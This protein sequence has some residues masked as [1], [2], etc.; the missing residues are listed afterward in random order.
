MLTLG[1]WIGFGLLSN[2]GT[3]VAQGRRALGFLPL[4]LALL[5]EGR[6]SHGNSL[7]LHRRVLLHFLQLIAV[8][9]LLLGC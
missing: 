8:L 7:T 9:V 5:A 3:L 4:W 6:L 2:V 1:L